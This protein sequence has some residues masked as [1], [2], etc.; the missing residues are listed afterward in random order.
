MSE[1]THTNSIV[2][3]RT[4]PHPPQKVWKALTTSELIAQWLMKNDFTPDV[5]KRFSFHAA[6]I[7]GLWN[8]VTDCEVLTVEPPHRL[9][10]SWCASGSEAAEGLKTVVT[11]TLT[12]VQGGTLVRME[13]AGF[14]PQA[15]AQ[16]Y[17]MMGSG[18]IRIVARLEEISAGG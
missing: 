10:Y 16:G 8:G 2:V 4:M 17:Q 9:A 1:P 14:R 13:Q 15:D 3:E 5:G 11:W 18:W 7:P 12:P 6:P